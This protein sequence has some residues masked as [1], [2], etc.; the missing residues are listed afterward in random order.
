MS[1]ERGEAPEVVS[2][3][4]A[5]IPTLAPNAAPTATAA[6][7]P[8]ESTPTPTPPPSGGVGGGAGAAAVPRAAQGAQEP[9]GG[10]ISVAGTGTAQ[11]KPDTAYVTLGFGSRDESLL[12]AQK[13][14]AEKMAAV[15]DRLRRSGVA[16]K[17]IQTSQYTISRNQKKK[18]FN[19]S[20]RVLVTI[21]DIDSAGRLL[22]GAVHAGANNVQGITF[23]IQD[24][25]ALDAEARRAAMADAKRKAATL[26][27]EGG[28]AVGEPISISEGAGLY[29]DP[30]LAQTGGGG[31][32]GGY[33]TPIQPGQLTVSIGVQ[34]RYAIR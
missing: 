6:T 14:T 19:V 7:S 10:S 5:A 1:G 17:D 23:G 24:R 22:D 33:E 12:A 9:L 30:Y 4:S 26:A 15:L 27:R 21:R 8:P 25:A 13:Q 2:R 18:L 29:E 11:G 3:R 16:A 31:G 34:V 28:V 20:N 32:G